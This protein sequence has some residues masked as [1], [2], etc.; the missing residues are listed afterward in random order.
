M[1]FWAKKSKLEHF[2]NKTRFA[3]VFTGILFFLCILW[4]KCLN[5]PVFCV[6]GKIKCL[7][8]IR[9]FI[10]YSWC[11]QKD[12]NPPQWF[13][14]GDLKMPRVRLFVSYFTIKYHIQNLSIPLYICILTT[15]S[16]QTILYNTSP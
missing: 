13:R 6:F 11:S 5:M 3:Y 8:K 16:Y 10:N 1:S 4:C 12:S 9:H 15:S 14:R 2:A 7:M